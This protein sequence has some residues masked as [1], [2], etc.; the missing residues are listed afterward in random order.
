MEKNELRKSLL[1]LRKNLSLS[2]QERASKEVTEKLIQL[3]LSKNISS[4]HCYLPIQNEIDTRLFISWCLNNK[5]TVII[6]KTL[7]NRQLKHCILMSL[8]ELETGLYGT[9]YPKNEIE[10]QG[11]Y[12]LICV[13]AVGFDRD[14]NRLGYG[15]GYYDNFLNTQ[16]GALK[17][18]LAHSCQMVAHLPVEA[19]DVS[20]DLVLF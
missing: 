7:K 8:S 20:M 15:A 9:L 12:D 16:K 19:H 6:P 18:G 11:T 5:I 14:G 4:V 17:V 2:E 3:S 1:C 10:Y 13:P